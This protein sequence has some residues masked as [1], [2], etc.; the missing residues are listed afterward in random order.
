MKHT[1]EQ[2]DQVKSICKE[3]FSKKLKD[4]G[5]AWRI[6]R[7]ASVTDQI[8]IKANRIRSIEIKGVSKVDEGER[9]ELIGIVNYCI[10]G[11]IQLELGFS[12][13]DDLSVEK[14][15]ELYG[16]YIEEAKKL[17]LAKKS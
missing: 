10:I 7:P 17:M 2:F 11:L 15:I 8:F 6:L 9:S 4:Y 16:K 5:A 13:S 14:A 3:I 12:E 1:E